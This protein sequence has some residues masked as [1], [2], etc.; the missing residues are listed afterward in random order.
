MS[1]IKNY[2]TFISFGHILTSSTVKQQ[3]ELWLHLQVIEALLHVTKVTLLL[4]N[5]QG[6]HEFRKVG[7]FSIVQLQYRFIAQR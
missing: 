6:V 2:P 3:Q 4:K 7:L 1:H 5:C